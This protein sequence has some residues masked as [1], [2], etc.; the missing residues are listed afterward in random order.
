MKKFT[1][2]VLVLLFMAIVINSI[3]TK[4]HTIYRNSQ[5]TI[6]FNSLYV[7]RKIHRIDV[8]M[9]VTG[10]C[11]GQFTLNRMYVKYGNGRKHYLEFTGRTFQYTHT[12]F[13]Y[14]QEIHIVVDGDSID[15]GRPN[16]RITMGL[17]ILHNGYESIIVNSCESW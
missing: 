8:I 10:Y 1:P 9:T 17:L 14:P 3:D 5:V 11:D 7:Y 2:I 4:L 12:Y 16:E 15:W 13:E 6:A